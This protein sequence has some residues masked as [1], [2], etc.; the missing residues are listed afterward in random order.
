MS[1]DVT[2]RNQKAVAGVG[3]AA[4][5]AGVL[6]VGLL[7]REHGPG[8]MGNGMLVGAGI[9][10]V[11]VVLVLVRLARHPERATTFERAWSQTGDERDDAVLTR[12]LAVVGLLSLPLTA[13]A[14]VAVALGV[15][16]EMALALLL[17][18]LVG[19]LATAFT[20]IQRRS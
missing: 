10:L 4:L 7:L 16:P 6:A 18:A 14:A 17:F 20:L 15:E 13:T 5:L 2:T 3:F 9:G 11:A 1:P 19:A 8:N 12:S